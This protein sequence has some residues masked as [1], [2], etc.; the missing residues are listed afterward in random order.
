[1]CSCMQR[2]L[3]FAKNQNIDVERSGGFGLKPP[4]ASKASSTILHRFGGCKAV[5]EM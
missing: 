5:I 1:M 3:Y 2:L 4:F